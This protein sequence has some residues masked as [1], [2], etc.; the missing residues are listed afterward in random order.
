MGYRCYIKGQTAENKIKDELCLGKCYGYNEDED[1]LMLGYT[2]IMNTPQYKEQ[3]KDW[4]INYYTDYEIVDTIFTA[5]GSVDM[6]LL[7]D[8]FI[9]FLDLYLLDYKKVWKRECKLTDVLTINDYLKDCISVFVE[10]W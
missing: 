4:D 9:I 2:F 6:H 5:R 1:G 7:T 3:R 8:D 10:W